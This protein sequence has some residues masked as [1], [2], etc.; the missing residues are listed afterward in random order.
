MHSSA[1][2]HALT[3]AHRYF[4]TELRYKRLFRPVLR[5]NESLQLST[6]ACQCV[7]GFLSETPLFQAERL[8]EQLAQLPCRRHLRYLIPHRG[9]HR[10][11]TQWCRRVSQPQTQAEPRC[12]RQTSRNVPHQSPAKALTGKEAQAKMEEIFA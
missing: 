2:S 8:E 3:A 1:S 6:T 12:H 7:A 5:Q 10:Q 9:T 11:P 4:E